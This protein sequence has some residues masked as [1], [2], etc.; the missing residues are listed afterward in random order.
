MAVW[1]TISHPRD[2]LFYVPQIRLPRAYRN[3]RVRLCQT[4]TPLSLP[5]SDNFFGFE[6]TNPRGPGSQSTPLHTLIKAC[7]RCIHVLSLLL[8]LI[9]WSG[10]LS[11]AM[12]LVQDL[13]VIHFS[14]SISLGSFDK[15]GS[16]SDTPGLYLAKIYLAKWQNWGSKRS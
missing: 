11:C 14:I 9:V 8:A 12:H 6:M 7:A 1:Q 13:W 15:P 4:D 5:Q 16:P 2:F 10:P 3:S